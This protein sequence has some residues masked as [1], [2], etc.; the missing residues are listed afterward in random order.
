MFLKNILQSTHLQ[1]G[2]KCS[3]E[4]FFK[5]FKNRYRFLATN[6]AD[7]IEDGPS[8]L[9]VTYILV[10]HRQTRLGEINS[11]V[12]LKRPSRGGPILHLCITTWKK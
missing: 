3:C 9:W 10:T 2:A 1:R 11:Y 6:G 8:E 5:T 4:F 7:N 12:H